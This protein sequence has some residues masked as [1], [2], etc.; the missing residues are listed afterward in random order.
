MFRYDGSK[1][2]N[3]DEYTKT[4]VQEYLD[5]GDLKEIDVGVKEAMGR[6]IEYVWLDGD[7]NEMWYRG[8][9]ID[10]EDNGVL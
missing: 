4:Q 2:E 3:E 5:N 9:V 6:D 10:V 1:D 7:L 8:R